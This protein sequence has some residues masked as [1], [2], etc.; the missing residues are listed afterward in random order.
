MIDRLGLFD[1]FSLHLKICG[2]IT[3]GRGDTGVTKPLADRKYVDPRSQQM[4][5]GAMAHAVGV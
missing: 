2:G 3:V 1:G 5:C 4:Y